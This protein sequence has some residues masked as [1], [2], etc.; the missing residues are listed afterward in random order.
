M[1]RYAL[2]YLF[3]VYSD[4]SYCIIMATKTARV[5]SSVHVTVPSVTIGKRNAEEVSLETGNNMNGNNA[6]GSNL[7]F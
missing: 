4:E 3:S 5:L 1:A 7:Y 6:T 2:T